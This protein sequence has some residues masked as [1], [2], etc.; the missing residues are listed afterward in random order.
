MSANITA[1]TFLA[2]PNV[3]SHGSFFCGA[4]QSGSEQNLGWMTSAHQPHLHGFLC[5]PWNCCR[6]K[7]IRLG[8]DVDLRHLWAGLGLWALL[9]AVVPPVVAVVVAALA[10]Q[11]PPRGQGALELREH[12]RWKLIQ[13]LRIEAEPA[14]GKLCA[15]TLWLLGRH[16]IAGVAASL[17]ATQRQAG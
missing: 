12:V 10:A 14:M 4:L 6:I 9:A 13:N 1:V 15:C 8:H 5:L 16:C 2:L 11:V 17:L 7:L 3:A